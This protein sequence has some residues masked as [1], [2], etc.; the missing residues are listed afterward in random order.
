V[1]ILG[2][3][4][5]RLTSDILK[6]TL[7]GSTVAFTTIVGRG[8]ADIRNAVNN[9]KSSSSVI[10]QLSKYDVSFFNKKPETW[11]KS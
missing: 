3:I 4:N 7:R 10:I 5:S 8:F 6:S 11:V 9:I 1:S 2:D